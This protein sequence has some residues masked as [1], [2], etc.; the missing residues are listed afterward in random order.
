MITS[1]GRSLRCLFWKLLR[2]RLNSATQY[3]I[4]VNEEA[5][6]PGVESTSAL[7]LVGLGGVQKDSIR[8][9]IR[10]WPPSNVEY[11]TSEEA[12]FGF[13]IHAVLEVFLACICKNFLHCLYTEVLR[14][15]SCD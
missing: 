11:S 6:S 14:N 15:K 4:V 12:R 10:Y 3:F 1:F 13:P 2:P 5:D 8:F 9:P 7:I